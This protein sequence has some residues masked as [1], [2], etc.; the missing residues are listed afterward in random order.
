MRGQH[1]T[2]RFDYLFEPL[3]GDEID[4]HADENEADV[5]NGAHRR[6]RSGPSKVLLGAVTLAAVTGTTATVLLLT[7]SDSVEPASSVTTPDTTS[8]PAPAPLFPDTPP[9]AVTVP[10]AEPPAPPPAAPVTTAVVASPEVAPPPVAVVPTPE[11]TAAVAPDPSTPPQPSVT[12]DQPEVTVVNPA[13]ATRAPMSVQP[14]PRQAFPNQPAPEH[15][16]DRPRGGLLG[17]GGLL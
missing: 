8:R 6:G 13:P 12:A 14:E 4:D 5:T 16:D 17:G 1:P 3:D 15:G 10:A 2:Q 11:V 9:L 7:R